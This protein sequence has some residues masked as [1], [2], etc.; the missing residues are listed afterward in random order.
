LI[1]AIRVAERVE[2][3][4]SRTNAE[5]VATSIHT[6]DGKVVAV[7]RIVEY[8]YSFKDQDYESSTWTPFAPAVYRGSEWHSP[9]LKGDRIEVFVDP[10]YPKSSYAV[11]FPVPRAEV[12]R[13][14]RSA[15]T[16]G[17]I[18]LFASATG[19]FLIWLQKKGRKT[20]AQPGATDNPDDAQRLRED[21]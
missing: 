6:S 20:E 10:H 18:S 3:E 11:A 7:D 1:Q 17:T 15:T 4:W 16:V 12:E 2:R 14:V 5:V 9:L 8:R 19:G 21:H 13:K